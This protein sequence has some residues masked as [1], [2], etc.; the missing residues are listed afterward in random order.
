MN[1]KKHIISIIIAVI[2]LIIGEYKTNS[3]EL[4]NSPNPQ[5]LIE[6]VYDCDYQT[7]DQEIQ[8]QLLSYVTHRT[9][10]HSKRV[11]NIPKEDYKI[12]YSKK[13]L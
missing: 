8:S 9:T 4:E 3:I 2:V 11:N 6:F 7:L 10:N 12:G 1:L 13:K 5:S